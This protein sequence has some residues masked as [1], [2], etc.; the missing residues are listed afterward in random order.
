MD[1]KRAHLVLKGTITQKPVVKKVPTL[2]SLHTFL[3]TFTVSYKYSGSLQVCEKCVQ[4]F[5]PDC[6]L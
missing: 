3:S 6:E 5:F 2:N 1:I 4:M